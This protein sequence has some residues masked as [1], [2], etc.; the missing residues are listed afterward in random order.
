M[1]LPL[2]ER[3]KTKPR[4]YFYLIVLVL[5][6]ISY[7]ACLPTRL[8]E[9]PYSSVLLSA[10]GQLLNARIA[11]D[12]QWR[13]P[14]RTQVPDKFK[15]AIIAFEDKRFESHIGVDFIALIR[16]IKSNLSSSKR[17]SGASTLTMQTVRLSRNNPARTY[18]EKSKEIILATR[19]EFSFGKDEVLAMYSAHAPFGGN[20]VGLEAASWRYFGRAPQQLSWAESAMLAVLPNN[21][22]YIHL[23]K[24][25]QRLKLKRDRLLQKLF[26][27]KTLSKLDL[28]LALVEKL[29]ENKLQMPRLAPHLLDT[30][31]RGEST[32]KKAA[33]FRTSLD[34]SI[35][36]QLSQMVFQYSNQL[37]QRGIDHAAA[38]IIDNNDF[39]VKAYV[40]NGRYGN[41]FQSGDSIDLIRRARSSGSIF[42]PLLY[43]AMLEHGDI[44]PTTLVA[45][46]P[47]HYSGYAPQNYDR[48]YRGAVPAKVALAQSLNIPAV[49]L[50]QRYG[51]SRFY[52]FLTQLGLTTLHRPPSEYGLPLILGGA[53]TTLWEMAQAY[54]NLASI[55]KNPS[56]TNYRSLNILL[57]DQQHVSLESKNAIEIGQGAA[58]LTLQALLEVKRPGNEN[59]WKNFQSS[60]KIAWKT[61]TSYGLKDGWAIGV[62]QKWTVAVWVGNANGAG[63]PSLTGVGA[64]APLLFDIFNQLDKSLWFEMP[65]HGLKAVT[66]CKENGYLSNGKCED[67]IQWIP[68]NSHFDRVT[69][70]HLEIHVEKNSGWRVTAECERVRNMKTIN[71]FVLPPGQEFYYQRTHSRY[72]AMPPFR[73]DCLTTATA[74]SESPMAFIY[75]QKGTQVYIPRSLDG[76]RSQVIF[77]AVH[78]QSDT[79]IYW[80]IDQQ[81]LGT[82]QVYHQLPVSL[83]PGWHRLTIVDNNGFSLS[84]KFKVLGK[85]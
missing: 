57:D 39:A 61:G 3:L 23:G 53:E 45:D 84:Q 72:T 7:W 6:S 12:Q 21:P 68:K 17:I 36:K 65:Y 49:R 66:A 38:L 81:Y 77:E 50:L 26:D 22:S 29:P 18:W 47:T 71:Q 42:K 34:F 4:R 73:E 75:P 28:N 1:L 79:A 54:A 5:L 2:I 8:F 41:R 31:S 13:F 20:V 63:V 15:Q 9:V 52:D 35:Q 64:A 85:H 25:R 67:E 62:T 16:A 69:P 83:D 19:I 24:N 30:L 82:T 43:A 44:I 37:Q 60:Q 70:H 46:L 76:S 14:P 80:H 48:S 32:N 11:K 40:G 55:A 59:F 78:R 10:D 51:V 74:N 58:W 56:Q 27:N 33:F